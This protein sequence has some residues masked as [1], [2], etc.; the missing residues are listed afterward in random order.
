[1][2]I[3][4]HKTKQFI[5]DASIPL[6]KEKGYAKVTMKDICAT[7]NLSRGGL[8]RHFRSTKE[9]FTEILSTH[10]DGL[11]HRLEQNILKRIPATILFDQYLQTQNSIISS[12]KNDLNLALLEFAFFESDQKEKINQ[13]IQTEI[14]LLSILFDYGQATCVFND[15]DPKTIACTLVLFFHGIKASSSFL[16]MDNASI[17]TQLAFFRKL[18]IKPENIVQSTV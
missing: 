4:G 13:R 12:K 7:C 17:V 5:I 16:T 9:I 1:M 3:K 6:F 18:V 14:K 10:N 2:F 15:F 8:Y 11:Q